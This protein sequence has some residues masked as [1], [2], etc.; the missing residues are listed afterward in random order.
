MEVQWRLIEIQWSLALSNQG[1]IVSTNVLMLEDLM[2]IYMKA[3]HWDMM[4][5]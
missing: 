3:L 5:L 2:K 1:E 4:K